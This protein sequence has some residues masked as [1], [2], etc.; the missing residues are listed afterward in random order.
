MSSAFDRYQKLADSR[1]TAQAQFMLGF[2]HAIGD[3]TDRAPRDQAKAYIYFS[4]AA[5]TRNIHANMALGYR[6]MAGI[7]VE[8]SCHQALMYYREAADLVTTEFEQSPPGWHRMGSTKVRLSSDEGGVYGPGAS[9]S[10][11][12]DMNPINVAHTQDDV[13]QFY[14][15]NAERGDPAAQLVLGQLYYQGTPTIPRNFEKAFKYL[16]AAAMQLPRAGDSKKDVADTN[17]QQPQPSTQNAA[18]GAALL[19][20]MYWR[21]DGVGQDNSTALRWFHRAAEHGNAAGLNSL[22]LMYQKGIVVPKNSD[23]ALQFFQKAADYDHA[24]AQVNLALVLLRQLVPDYAAALKYLTMATRQGHMLAL[25]HLGRLYEKGVGVHASCT[26]A[27]TL[28]KS[29]VEKRANTPSLM[30]DAFQAYQRKDFEGALLMYLI[31]GELGFEVAQSNAAWILDTEK[32]VLHSPQSSKFLG[33]VQ[34]NRAANLGNVDARIKVGDYHYYGL[35]TPV[36]YRRAAQYYQSADDDHSA[37]AMFNLAVMHENGIGIHQDFH[38]AKRYYD[39]ALQTNPEA[40]LPVTLAMWSL[41]F[42]YFLHWLTHGGSFYLDTPLESSTSSEEHSGSEG[43]TLLNDQHLADI[44]RAHEDLPDRFDAYK[45]NANNEEEIGDNSGDGATYRGNQELDD[46]IIDENGWE[47]IIGNYG[48]DSESI[49]VIV[50]L[51]ALAFLVWA[52]QAPAA[53]LQ[54]ANQQPPAVPIP[55]QQVDE[56]EARRRRQQNEQYVQ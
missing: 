19:G 55:R 33:L 42:K 15:F 54:R 31:A 23:K 35:G 6:Y 2:Y 48:E 18:M 46:G 11:A 43:E 50:L 9:G 44:L 53:V 34:W 27:L 5:G 36:N 41:R 47:A 21:G 51:A 30:S 22:G 40:T 16:R 3:L 14:H 20:Q 17:P 8:K 1:G 52:R 45:N 56:D 49:L 4:F 25:Y 26:V 10:G 24:D 28:Y 29:S 38:L 32:Y 37:M 7:G 12:P 39:R 13:V